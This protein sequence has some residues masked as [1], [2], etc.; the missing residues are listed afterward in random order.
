M[1]SI[2]TNIVSYLI[3]FQ[4]KIKYKTEGNEQDDPL[5]IT[6]K[7][8]QCLF[9]VSSVCPQKMCLLLHRHKISINPVIPSSIHSV[10]LCEII[11]GY[12][13]TSVFAGAEY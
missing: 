8:T 9:K 3:G 7:I 2:N 13:Q 10:C 11:S 1:F 12:N 6:L 4:K 5:K